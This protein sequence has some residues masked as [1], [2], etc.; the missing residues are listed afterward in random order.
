MAGE[1]D[2]HSCPVCGL[3]LGFEPR[4][5]GSPPDEICPCCGIQFGYD[6]A[7]GPQ[8]ARASVYTRWREDWVKSGMPW[9][10]KGRPPPADWDPRKQ[11][12]GLAAP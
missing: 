10:S 2:E 4:K 1:N 11:L 3:G 9:F 7:V 8:E 6:D 5:G 12:Q